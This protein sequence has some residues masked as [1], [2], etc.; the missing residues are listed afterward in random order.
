VGVAGQEFDIAV[1]SHRLHCQR[2]GRA[3]APLVVGV[4]GLSLNMKAFDYL[5]E[6]LDDDFQLVAVDLR[7][8]G[9]SPPTAP[10]S[11]GWKNHALD[12]LAVADALGFD[13]FAIIGQSMGGSVAMKAAEIRPDRI[14]ALV[15]VD[16]AGRVDR[17]AGEFI[18]SVM[19]SVHDEYRSVDA[20]LDAIRA[21]GL[22]EDWS[23]YW[24][25][26][27]R[28][29]IEVAGDRVR[30]RVNR[31]ALAEDRRYAATEGG[32]LYIYERWKY[33][34]MPTLLLRATREFRPGIGHVVPEDDRAS[35]LRDVPTG[36]IVEIA[37]NHLTINTHPM[38]VEAIRDFLRS[39]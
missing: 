15:L 39:S 13:R 17:G 14:T 35:F 38:T 34:T 27:Y 29:G 9:H 36:S 19:A 18:G 32:G 21:Q 31:D 2:F 3:S 7:G 20:Y 28:Y 4:H 6:N 8:R 5:G 11:Y 26:C 24:E 12:V 33:L 37:A 10:G 22:V 1:R 16:V 23:A 25:R 30:A